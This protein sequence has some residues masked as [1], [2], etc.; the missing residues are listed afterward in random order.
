MSIVVINLFTLILTFK[1]WLTV[2]NYCTVARWTWPRFLA[3]IY[4]WIYPYHL[5]YVIGWFLGQWC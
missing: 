5:S 4:H 2:V 3:W 1:V